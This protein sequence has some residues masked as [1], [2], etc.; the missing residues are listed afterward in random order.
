M[1]VSSKSASQLNNL[2]HFDSHY[3]TQQAQAKQL[4]LAGYLTCISHNNHMRGYAISLRPRPHPRLHPHH[5][6]HAN[7]R[8]LFV[9]RTRVCLLICDHLQF[10]I[11]SQNWFQ[12]RSR[13]QLD[14]QSRKPLLHYIMN[15]TRREYFC[16]IWCSIQFMTMWQW[17]SPLL[18]LTMRGPVSTENITGLDFINVSIERHWWS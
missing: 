12:N 8:P 15:N 5:N 1:T 10:F 11:R 18:L 17:N 13:F 2:T 6:V 14:D 3:T 16:H 9:Y 7:S 4:N